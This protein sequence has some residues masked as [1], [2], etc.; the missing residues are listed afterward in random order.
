VNVVCGCDL[1]VE[2]V[3][4]RMWMY[5]LVFSMNLMCMKSIVF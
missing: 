1:M 2:K 4:V 3:Y 5:V